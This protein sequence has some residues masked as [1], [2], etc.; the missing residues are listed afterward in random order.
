MLHNI[1]IVF[2]TLMVVFVVAFIIV[3]STYKNGNSEAKE[4]EI[5]VRWQRL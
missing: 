1:K 4:K 5:G 3:Y 2:R